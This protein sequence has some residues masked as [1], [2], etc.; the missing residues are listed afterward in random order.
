M[1]A[2]LAAQRL[3]RQR[4]I[5]VAQLVVPCTN[6]IQL[7]LFLHF[8]LWDPRATELAVPGQNAPTP[9]SSAAA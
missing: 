3:G 2:L 9:L 6:S 4:V 5:G 7:P 1:L 8:R